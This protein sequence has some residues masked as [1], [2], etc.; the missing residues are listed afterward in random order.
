M[1]E[2]ILAI[3][4]ISIF[5][6]TTMSLTRMILAHR[7]SMKGS[8]GSSSL[9]TS[10]LERMMRRAVEEAT[11]PLHRKIEDLEHDLVVGQDGRQL[12]APRKDLLLDLEDESDHAVDGESAVVRAPRSRD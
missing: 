1:P 10:E 11:E 8:A 6:G 5:A 4:I 9:T 12:A 7:R 2:E 3:I